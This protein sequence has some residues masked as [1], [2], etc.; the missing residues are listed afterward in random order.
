MQFATAFIFG[1]VLATAL[2]GNVFFVKWLP[3]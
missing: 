2:A 3:T 1:L